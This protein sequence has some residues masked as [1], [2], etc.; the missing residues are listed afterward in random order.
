MLF[1]AYENNFEQLK[2]GSIRRNS[3]EIGRHNI[4]ALMAQPVVREWWNGQGAATLTP[5]FRR[6]IEELVVR[7]DTRID[8]ASS[9]VFEPD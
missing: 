6:A 1:L 2:L 4:A 3:F 8:R 5:E 7:E 9:T